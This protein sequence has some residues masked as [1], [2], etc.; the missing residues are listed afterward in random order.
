MLNPLSTP[1]STHSISATAMYALSL[2]FPYMFE[3]KNLGIG[4]Y[5]GWF[6]IFE[7]LC[8]DIDQALGKD[9]LNFGWDQV[10]E[11]FG[12]ARFYF[13]PVRPKKP[14][15]GAT[16]E[17]AARYLEGVKKFEAIQKLV[18]EAEAQT[19]QTCALCGRPGE[20]DESVYFVLTLCQ[21]HKVIRPFL[22]EGDWT[23][24]LSHGRKIALGKQNGEG[25]Q[26]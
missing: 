8:E 11:K 26:T 17:E 3:R 14:H 5:K 19:A 16:S 13:S 12:T 23:I 18:W 10:K 7:K 1:A 6:T 21:D 25:Q 20:L 22:R 24:G 15:E 9:K 2:R 4:T